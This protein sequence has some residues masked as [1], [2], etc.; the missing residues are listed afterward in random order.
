VRLEIKGAVE[1]QEALT[2]SSGASRDTYKIRTFRRITLG[3]NVVADN[4]T[5][6]IFWLVKDLGPVQLLISP[7][8]ENLGHF[9]VL[10]LKNF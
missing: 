5:T 9:R 8:T 10:K 1:A 2:D 4:V 7:D 6:A 3:T